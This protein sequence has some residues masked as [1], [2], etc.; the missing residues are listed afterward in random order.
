MHGIQHIT[1][2]ILLAMAG[3]LILFMIIYRLIFRKRR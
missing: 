3:G 2:G 1:P